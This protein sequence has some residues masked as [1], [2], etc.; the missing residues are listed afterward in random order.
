MN[1]PRSLVVGSIAVLCLATRGQSQLDSPSSGGGLSSPFYEF[2]LNG[3]DEVK[4][5]DL[6]KRNQRHFD[7]LAAAL[8]VTNGELTRAQ[9][10]TLETGSR[11]EQPERSIR[12]PSL[13]NILNPSAATGSGQ[14]GTSNPS[15]KPM[16]AGTPA[17]PATNRQ[18]P[19][20]NSP[21]SLPAPT[22]PLVYHSDNL[23][24][25]LPAWFR[26][27]D[28]NHDAQIGLYEWKVSGRPLSEFRQID[29]NNDGFLT[30][31]EVLRYEAKR[32]GAGGMASS[33]GNGDQSTFANQSSN[34]NQGGGQ[35]G[36]R[37]FNGQGGG[38][39]NAFPGGGGRGNGGRRGGGR[40]NNGNG[41]GG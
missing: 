37:I 2:L 21:S 13:Q 8:G 34:G 7:R 19:Q 28:T 3:K 11:P 17:V 20:W 16:T 32:K 27:L 4:R 41:G 31:D 1:I 24:K 9:L 25:E 35:G 26:Q 33:N 14:F 23:P 29:R 30:I 6:D 18:P 22:A 15:A 38:G 40:G 5:A 10:S 39:N 12:V 36:P